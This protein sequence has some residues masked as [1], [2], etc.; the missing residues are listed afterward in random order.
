MKVNGTKGKLVIIG[1]GE[2]KEG[3]CTILKEFVRLAGDSKARIAVMTVA[4]DK[5]KEYADKYKKVFKKLGV[6]ET[7]M[8]DVSHRKDVHDPKALEIIE[9]A[10]GI[11]FTGG[12]QLHIPCTMGG[13]AEFQTGNLLAAVAA[14]RAYGVTC[15]Q[16]RNSLHNFNSNYNPGRA[17]LYNVNGGYVLVDYGHN[18]DAF[19]A[20]CRMAARWH[21]R[22]VTGIIGV[23]GDRDDS[24]VEQA[25]RVAGRGF[26][27]VIIK[28]D[29]D[30]RGREKGEVARLLC[31]AVNDESP[32][33][34]CRIVLDEIMALRSEIE[35]LREGQVI[36]VFYDRLEPLLKVLKDFGAAPVSIIEEPKPMNAVPE[37]AN[38]YSTIRT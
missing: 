12:D 21:D 20:V 30:L 29:T 25:G 24:L 26:H 1:G 33:T 16:L 14:C 15:A 36:V 19:A 17:N 2:D 3:D 4:T 7:R 10:T 6:A 27:R 35:G 5:P 28:E 32:D 22:S 13:T 31:Q 38:I 23:P 9:Q 34:E 37:S 18:P 11:F 8:V